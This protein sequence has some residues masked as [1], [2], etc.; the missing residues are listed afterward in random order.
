MEIYL[1][2]S[3]TS[4]RKAEEVIRA[5]GM[6]YQRRDYFKD[7]FTI[8]ELRALLER[9]RLTAGEALSTRSKAYTA[10]G[11]AEKDLSDEEILAL[12]VN[13]P[14]LLR[15]PLVLGDGSTVVGYNAS[16]IRALIE[17]SR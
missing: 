10:L 3:C 8:T 5:S 1:Y 2:S 9:A 12:M 7:R 16:G 6:P 17:Q 4:C 14:T 13:E 11:L 15:R